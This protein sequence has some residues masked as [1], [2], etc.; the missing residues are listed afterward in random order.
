MS[1]KH[2]DIAQVISEHRTLITAALL[3]RISHQTLRTTME[4]PTGVAVVA[5][6]SNLRTGAWRPTAEQGLQGGRRTPQT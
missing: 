1:Q 3:D 4:D 5:A 2:E 6:S